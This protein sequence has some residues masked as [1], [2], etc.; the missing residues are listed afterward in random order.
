MEPMIDKLVENLRYQ[1]NKHLPYIIM[2]N[3]PRIVNGV[4]YDLDGF[5]PIEPLTDSLKDLINKINDKM[6]SVYPHPKEKRINEYNPVTN[7]TFNYFPLNEN[8]RKIIRDIISSHDFGYNPFM[9]D[10]LLK[11]LDETTAIFI[12]K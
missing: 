10:R 12:S 6:L 5:Y 2:L 11:Q 7:N 9:K 8:R 1:G 4:L 3:N